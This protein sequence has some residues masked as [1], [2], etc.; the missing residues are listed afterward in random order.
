MPCKQLLMLFTGLLFFILGNGQDNCTQAVSINLPNNGFDPVA[1]TRS[2]DIDI[3]GT[4]IESGES[5]APGSITAGQNQKSIWFRFNIPTAR[6][7]TITVGQAGTSILPGEVG[8]AVYKSSGCLPSASE[9]S[10]KLTALADFGSR[11]LF[12][13]GISQGRG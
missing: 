2:A 13:T 10:N 4:T 7:V 6:S 12:G 5:F 11:Y 1:D 9:L 3:T 8:F